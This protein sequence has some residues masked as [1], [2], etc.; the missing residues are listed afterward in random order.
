MLHQSSD[1]NEL[2][3]LH[4]EKAERIS[5]LDMLLHRRDLRTMKMYVA[6]AMQNIPVK[7]AKGTDRKR[8]KENPM[9]R[10]FLNMLCLMFSVQNG[11][12]RIHKNRFTFEGFRAT[13]KSELAVFGVGYRSGEFTA[14]Q[15]RRCLEEAKAIGILTVLYE[16]NHVTQKTHMF[17]R[18]EPEVFIAIAVA[19]DD[20]Q[21]AGMR[22]APLRRKG[23]K[24][25]NTAMPQPNYAKSNKTAFSKSDRCEGILS[26]SSSFNSEVPSPSVV[27]DVPV[28]SS[29]L[30]KS[31]KR[32]SA[33]APA[34]ILLSDRE[35]VR[36]T[37]FEHL[38]RQ[39]DAHFHLDTMGAPERKQLA[40]WFDST[41]PARRITLS[42]FDLYRSRAHSAELATSL[43]GFLD[44]WPMFW[45]R[46]ELM[47]LQDQDLSSAQHAVHE[48]R[49]S[50]TL[51]ETMVH[52]EIAAIGCYNTTAPDVWSVDAL[53]RYEA[54]RRQPGVEGKFDFDNYVTL[55]KEQIKA[56]VLHNYIEAHYL[57]TLDP[58]L[59]SRLGITSFEWGYAKQ[60]FDKYV[61][62]A[63]VLV[64][65]ANTYI[66]HG[67]REKSLE[68]VIDSARR[69]G[70]R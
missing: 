30:K 6:R 49:R 38:T 65:T 25:K 60:C 48:I 33:A 9:Y 51:F 52:H 7:F 55:Y 61:A 45:Q 36:S 53:V 27:A 13:F 23:E 39:V 15:L 17:I 18:F 69:N 46:V 67:M 16:Y 57:A 12:Y 47:M 4:M 29:Q 43:K 10:D 37:E 1:P 5:L 2:L 42:R 11:D 63:T 20:A 58:S 56:A 70:I 19:A 50:K 31:K 32:A 28:L 14:W 44:H 64:C 54:L 66:D 62:K 3:R 68:A 21:K 8:F 26:H 59:L 24:K 22:E 35:D 40:A 41:H 34:A